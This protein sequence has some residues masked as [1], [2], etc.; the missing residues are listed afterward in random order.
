[1]LVFFLALILSS[2]SC[3]EISVESEDGYLETYEYFEENFTEEENEIVDWSEFDDFSCDDGLEDN[4]IKMITLPFDLTVS[5]NG[6]KRIAGVDLMKGVGT[7]NIGEDIAGLAY[8][9]TFWDEFG[10]TLYHVL[11]PESDNLNVVYIYCGM[12]S[13]NSLD[14]IWSESYSDSMMDETA[15]GI[16]FADINQTTTQVQIVFPSSLPSP[17]ELVTGFSVSGPF[18]NITDSDSS[19]TLNG[20]HYI[21][22][23]FE[24]VDC[25]TECT[26]N[27][28]DG[29]W[30]L[31]IV[32]D[33][34]AVEE[35]CFGILYLIL[36]QPSRVQFAYGFCFKNLSWI[37]AVWLDASWSVS[38]NK[39]KQKGKITIPRYSREKYLLRPQ[40]PLK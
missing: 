32:L 13:E 11:A 16:C 33:E 3:E 12:N 26:A 1:M 35:R 29:W 19:I 31:H 6:T 21:A 15:S 9:R 17:E 22:Y 28:S 39:F 40:P 38:Q 2:C 36:S 18:V 30:E 25:T 5:G 14:V 37:D 24:Y 7:I 4:E 27:P 8:F 20:N 23:P 34:E 10:I